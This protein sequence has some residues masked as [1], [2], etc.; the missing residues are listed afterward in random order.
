M[1]TPRAGAT[2]GVAAAFAIGVIG[3]MV[4]PALPDRSVLPFVA[5]L[6]AL[7]V[8]CAWD[9]RLHAGYAVACGALLGLC[10]GIYAAHDALAHRAGACIDGEEVIV[11]GRI[12]GLP[13]T[14][15][16]TTRFDVA[17]D[18]DQRRS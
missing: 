7:V 5:P 13:L 14:G 17:L 18:V 1:Q 11:K 9:G 16:L 4:L 2:N 10:W 12:E 6:A 8:L 15:P 3:A